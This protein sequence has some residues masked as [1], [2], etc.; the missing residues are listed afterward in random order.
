MAGRLKQGSLFAYPRLIFYKYAWLIIFDANGRIYQFIPLHNAKTIY[1]L[2]LSIIV[3]TA[4]KLSPK[5][6]NEL[7]TQ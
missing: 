6:S 1:G 3:Q 2:S 4:S 5:V 7:M